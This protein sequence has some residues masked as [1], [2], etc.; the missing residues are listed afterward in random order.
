[1]SSLPF[2][3]PDATSPPADIAMPLLHVTLPFHEA[4]TS[5]L[6]SLHLPATLH[7]IASPLEPKLK[8]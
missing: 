2:S 6:P 4:K 8:H 1:V 3:I 7:L 5:L